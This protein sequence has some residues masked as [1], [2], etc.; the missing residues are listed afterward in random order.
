MCVC[1]CIRECVSF[2]VERSSKVKKGVIK[3]FSGRTKLNRVYVELTE[4]LLLWYLSH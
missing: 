3:E 2:G 1:T 4:S